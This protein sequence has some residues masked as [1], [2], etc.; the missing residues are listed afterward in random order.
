MRQG[1]PIIISNPIV[2]CSVK[3]IYID[4]LATSMSAQT[5]HATTMVYIQ[6]YLFGCPSRPCHATRFLGHAAKVNKKRSAPYM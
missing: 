1:G 2:I 4:E 5:L 6:G 3:L